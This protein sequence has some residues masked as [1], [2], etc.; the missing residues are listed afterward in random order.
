[1]DQRI[2]FKDYQQLLSIFLDLQQQ[3]LQAALLIDDGGLTRIEGKITNIKQ[4]ENISN[5]TITID[6]K[7]SI[8]LEKVIAVNGLFRDDYSE[9]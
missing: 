6:N 4:S 3:Q 8:P 1:M 2:T 9:C 7:D 5:S